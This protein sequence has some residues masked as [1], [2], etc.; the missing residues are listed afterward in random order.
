MYD[1]NGGSSLD[2]IIK[3]GKW[4]HLSKGLQ[5]VNFAGRALTKSQKAR[6]AQVVKDASVLRGQGTGERWK[7]DVV[8][9]RGT[10][11]S[12]KNLENLKEFGKECRLYSKFDRKIIQFKTNESEDL[13]SISTLLFNHVVSISKI[14]L[15]LKVL[16]II[17]SLCYSKRSKIG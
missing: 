15:C 9:E 1:W 17:V 10:D 7:R 6:K 14:V 16:N 2:W 4:G 5:V 13:T 8:R 12:T 3:V 11:K